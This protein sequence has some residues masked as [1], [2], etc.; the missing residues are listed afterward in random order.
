M[1]SGKS[2]SVLAICLFLL[3]CSHEKPA[4]IPAIAAKVIVPSYTLLA[5]QTALLANTAETACKDAVINP[6]ELKQLR[7]RWLIAMSA[8]QQVKVF[9]LETFNAA[10]S[11]RQ[12]YQFWPDLQNETETVVKDLLSSTLPLTVEVIDKAGI[13]AQGFSALEYLLFDKYNKLQWFAEAGIPAGQHC[14]F[15]QHTAKQLSADSAK[16]ASD[17]SEQGSV[18]QAF[19]QP[20][21][22]DAAVSALAGS[23]ITQLEL[24]KTEKI[25]KPLGIYAANKRPDIYLTEAWRSRESLT[26]IRA[27]IFIIEKILDAPDA[28]LLSLLEGDAGKITVAQK[29]RAQISVLK[30]ALQRIDISMNESLK[31]ENGIAALRDLLAAVDALSALCRNELP[32]ALGV[33]SGVSG[34]K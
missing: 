2:A 28:G 30:K 9:R 4:F 25:A 21:V 29:I 23:V 7:S 27:N 10:G 16:L 15:L 26:L 19:E 12:Q 17:W 22:A 8:W 11:T 3:S 18:R 24:I 13:P 33:S 14:R 6:G 5:G 31:S 1:I 20:E 32:V 34:V